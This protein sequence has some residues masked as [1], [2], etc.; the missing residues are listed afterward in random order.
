MPH[1]VLVIEAEAVLAKN[2]HI[3]LERH[4]YEVHL[5]Q[6]AEEGLASPDS[7]RPDAVLLDFNL[8]GLDGLEALARIQAFDVTPRVLMITGH[9][10]VEMAVQDM[11]RGAR[12]LPHQAGG[13]G[14]AAV[15]A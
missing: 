2:I 4:G 14:Q 3:Y 8:A 13:A 15:A 11:K 7:V 6:S 12:R 9:G 1:A 5:A 10:S